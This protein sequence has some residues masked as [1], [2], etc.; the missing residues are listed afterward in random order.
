LRV[1]STAPDFDH[2]GAVLQAEKALA[3]APPGTTPL[4]AAA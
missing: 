4:L 3:V 2:E 1:W